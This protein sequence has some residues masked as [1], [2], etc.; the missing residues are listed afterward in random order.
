MT[1]NVMIDLETLGLGANAAVIS[2]GA[3]KFDPNG[4]PGVHGDPSNPEYKDF[5]V[6]LLM[7]DVVT[8]SKFDVDGST[9]Q[10]WMSSQITQD[11]RDMLFVDPMPVETALGMFWDWYGP[12]SVP[13]WGNGAGFDNV[14]LRNT[15]TRMQGACPFK[16]YDD[17]CFRTL[18]AL[19][20][21]VEY[22]KPVTPHYAL[23]D[24]VAQATH[25]QKL[26]NLL[27]K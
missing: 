9:I 6:N 1:I 2:I 7:H 14:I 13:T 25:V 23:S 10:W 26:F 20:P 8:Y 4:T 24:A 11:V 15:F 17:R 12:T 22:V 3:V 27:S 16:F 21:A 18:K 5:Y 19:F